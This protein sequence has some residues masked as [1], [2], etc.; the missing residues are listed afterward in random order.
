MLVASLVV[1]CI[2]AL[3]GVL[4]TLSVDDISATLAR[5]LVPT[6]SAPSR[7]MRISRYV[8]FSAEYYPM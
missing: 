4:Q 2:F 5:M 6:I 8:R 7:T 3:M 1:T